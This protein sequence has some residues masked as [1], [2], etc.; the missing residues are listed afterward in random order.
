MLHDITYSDLLTIDTTTQ[1]GSREFK[2]EMATGYLDFGDVTSLNFTIQVKLSSAGEWINWASE[3]ALAGTVYPAGSTITASDGKRIKYDAVGVWAAQIT[4]VSG[5]GRVYIG[6][7]TAPFIRQSPG[8]DAFGL[9]KQ[10][11]A[12]HATG[13]VGVM[14][15]YVRKDT[16]ADL[17]GADGD[18]AP[19]QLDSSGNIRTTN[20]AVDTTNGV[21]KTAERVTA[22]TLISG[23]DGGTLAGVG[24]LKR[25]MLYNGSGSAT[26]AEVYDN[27]AAS[28][29]K[30]T[31]TIPLPTLGLV[32]LELNVPYALGVYIDFATA[33]SCQALGYSQ[34]VA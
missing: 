24:V 19:G 3:D 10:D 17:A 6:S 21:M 18:Y 32:V 20:A 11:S 2:Q 34:A 14:G 5:T 33:T 23:A 25:L 1:T 4:W 7:S 16:Q 26:T 13:D 28:G 27:T 30:L 22:G 9:G 12:A 29:T 8:I 15:L 31:T